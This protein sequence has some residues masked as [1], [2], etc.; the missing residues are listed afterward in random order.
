MRC[1]VKHFD[2]IQRIRQTIVGPIRYATLY[3]R[4]VV[5]LRNVLSVKVCTSDT[6][7]KHRIQEIVEC[8]WLSSKRQ[9]LKRTIFS[10]TLVLII[11]FFSSYNTHMI[12]YKCFCKNNFTLCTFPSGNTVQ[13]IR[14]RSSADAE[15]PRD[16]PQIRNIALEKTYNRGFPISLPLQLWL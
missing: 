13:I 15:W 14:T 4:T 5:G 1:A 11:W 16:A 7:P 8:H 3:R 12:C 9:G 6:C 10:Q 2:T